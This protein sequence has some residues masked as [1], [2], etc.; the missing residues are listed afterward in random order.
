MEISL[1]S[2]V[3]GGLIIIVGG[4]NGFGAGVL[5]ILIVIAVMMVEAWILT[6]M[7]GRQ[8]DHL[9]LASP[10]QVRAVVE[11]SFSGVGWKRVNGRGQLNYKA[12]GFG[13]GAYGMKRPVVSVDITDRG[14]GST[15][16][17]IWTS[18][19]NSRSGMMA[20]CDRVVSKKFWLGHKLAALNPPMAAPPHPAGF[21]P[22]G[23]PAAQHDNS[24]KATLIN[25]QLPA[26]DRRQVAHDLVTSVGLSFLFY[27]PGGG[28]DCFEALTSLA[29]AL[30][31]ARPLE[32]GFVG[33]IP[34][35]PG[36]YLI[37]FEGPFGAGI[38]ICH[39][40]EANSDFS[41]EQIAF[42]LRD[43]RQPWQWGIGTVGGQVPADF[44]QIVDAASVFDVPP[45]A[46]SR[47]D[48][49]SPSYSA[50]PPNAGYHTPHQQPNAAITP[51]Q[52]WQEGQTP[53][54]A[55]YWNPQPQP[56]PAVTP[57]TQYQP[58]GHAPVHAGY[59]AGSPQH[60]P[61]APRPDRYQP[62]APAAA[63]AGYQPRPPYSYPA[64]TPPQPYLPQ[65]HGPAAHHQQPHSQRPDG[66]E[67][68]GQ[69][70]TRWE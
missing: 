8:H 49:S 56:H 57:P 48:Q 59:P 17:N 10:Q 19:W 6:F 54:G 38:A 7:A 34:G 25:P 9:V 63:N 44:A 20:L 16:V 37:G 13:L 24:V 36:I 29:P 31:S 18:E 52:P 69:G 3:V 27:G 26:T 66:Q 41:T 40:Q 65:P 23:S 33:E 51:P 1:I 67:K 4:L 14:D 70:Y 2:I 39:T 28:S 35:Q 5:A 12:R 68:F 58:Q 61:V 53:G 60:S 11:E 30:A 45:P 43:A 15:E 47:Y 50:P 64:I 62:G 46:P 21:T 32:G 22:V 42:R 55:G